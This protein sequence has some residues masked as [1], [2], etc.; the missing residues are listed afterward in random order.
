M[1]TRPRERVWG[2]MAARA[3]HRAAMTQMGTWRAEQNL[4]R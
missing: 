3:A 2:T 1:S 4:R